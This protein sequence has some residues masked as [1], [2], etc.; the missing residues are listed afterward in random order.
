MIKKFGLYIVLIVV[1]VTIGG[2]A[3]SFSNKQVDET[4]AYKNFKQKLAKISV[5]NID[6]AIVG[7][8]LTVK[9]LKNTKNQKLKNK[10]YVDY[11]A[12][13]NTVF[14]RLSF[15]YIGY[16][17]NTDIN[18]VTY[19]WGSCDN[20]RNK[21]SDNV[22]N[23]FKKIQKY[24]NTK[25]FDVYFDDGGIFPY[26]NE[27][28]LYKNFS[29]Y[30][31]KDWQTYLNILNMEHQKPY[32]V[33]ERAWL[34][35]KPDELR[36]RIVY[37][38]KIIIKYPYFERKKEL[39]KLVECGY[40]YTYFYNNKHGDEKGQK[41]DPELIKSYENF[42]KYNKDSKYYKNVKQFYNTLRDNNYEFIWYHHGY[43]EIITDIRYKKMKEE[44]FKSCK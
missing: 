16:K 41:S 24:I 37:V 10:A 8:D 4:T 30:L 6:S 34:I 31:S 3:I 18:N 43:E 17:C 40:Q 20:Q 25:G 13:Y 32:Y 2:F 14:D 29:Q 38:E 22:E 9:F 36:N 27:T 23:D 5:K 12:F 42:L 39:K 28:Y 1:F 33:G 11:E 26:K 44:F 15:T 35:I 19:A 7:K 21:I